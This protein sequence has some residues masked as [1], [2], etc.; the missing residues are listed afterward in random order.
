MNTR[1]VV[2]LIAFITACAAALVSCAGS[3][4]ALDSSSPDSDATE[5]TG[6]ASTPAQ[7][8]AVQ[9]SA[10]ND[11]APGDAAP[12]DS[13]SRIAEQ[14]AS[15]AAAAA[16]LPGRV[17]ADPGTPPAINILAT[18][19]PPPTDSPA[20]Q[21]ISGVGREP[22]AF[23]SPREDVPSALTNPLW[24]GFAS[25]VDPGQIQRGGPPP[26]G[27]PAI[28]NPVFAPAGEID[29]LAEN[30]AVIAVEI[31]EDERAYPLQ[32]MTRHEL[33]NDYV[34]GIPVTVS[35]CPLCNSGVVYDRR[36]GER[37]LDFGTSGSLY[38]SS[39]VMYD[40]Q[41]QTLW[42]HFDGTAVVG[43]LVG[44]Q[45]HFYPMAVVAWGDWLRAHPDG[46][47]L[48]PE[49]GGAGSYGQNP[50]VGYE[51]SPGLLSPSFQSE[52]FDERLPPKVRVIGIRSTTSGDAVAVRHDCLQSAGVISV[53]VN[54]V[55]LLVW[56][57]PGANS[58]IDTSRVSEGRDVGSTG[59]FES[60]AQALTFTRVATGFRDAETDSVWNVFGE[61]T[62][63]SM[64]GDALTP[65]EFLDTFWFAWGT[66]EPN[67]RIVPAAEAAC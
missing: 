3:G 53:E 7:S 35:Y 22:L 23:S 25:L 9:G 15:S 64:E 58:A 34:G 37:V 33:V 38:Q 48:T 17:Y 50:Y 52:P 2:L 42:T 55:P 54:G 24:P 32:I 28:D 29:F 67:T 47:V 12:N 20:P 4:D 16:L 1:L 45:L 44:V 51:D 41:T 26:D 8:D 5:N 14:Q 10:P 30:E 18:D 19:P 36:V 59:V 31:N 49:R 11:A 46:L 40:R 57:F 6:A 43:E 66:F 56:N 13:A 65:V 61:A 63:G 21:V 39:L 27:I 60:P 62:S